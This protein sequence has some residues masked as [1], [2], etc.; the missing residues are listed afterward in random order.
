MLNWAHENDLI[1][2]DPNVLDQSLHRT[3]PSWRQALCLSVSIMEDGRALNLHWEEP[4][5]CH[6]LKGNPEQLHTSQIIFAE[7]LKLSSMNQ[8]PVPGMS[9]VL[10]T[11]LLQA[12]ARPLL[13]EQWGFHFITTPG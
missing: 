9:L 10:L 4:V 13:C 11:G 6:E 2:Q 7:C 8:S 1:R 5:P 12:C 3:D